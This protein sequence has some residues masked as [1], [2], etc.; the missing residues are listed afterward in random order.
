AQAELLRGGTVALRFHG[1]VVAMIALDGQHAVFGD[2]VEE[3]FGF[4][5]GSANEARWV[6]PGRDAAA[7]A[8]PF[9]DGAERQLIAWHEAGRALIQKRLEGAA[10]IRAI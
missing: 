9:Q 2:L 1:F 5:A 3:G 7:L 10:K 4:F 8:D 6:C